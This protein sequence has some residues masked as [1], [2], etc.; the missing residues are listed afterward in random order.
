MAKAPWTK[1]GRK[2]TTNTQEREED[3]TK[4]VACEEDEACEP[5]GSNGA[6]TKKKEA[7]KETGEIKKKNRNRAIPR[8][9]VGPRTTEGGRRRRRG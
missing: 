3:G 8:N 9:T 6:P 5:C 7:N 4:T 2:E 1:T